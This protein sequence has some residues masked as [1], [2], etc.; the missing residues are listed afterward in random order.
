MAGKV[1]NNNTFSPLK[2]HS[3]LTGMKPAIC[4]YSY[5]WPL[6]LIGK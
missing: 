4:H 3:G 5:K 2:L 1:L 6:S